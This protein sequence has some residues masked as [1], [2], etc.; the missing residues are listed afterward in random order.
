VSDETPKLFFV[1]IQ[2]TA[3]GTLRQ[4]IRAN[5][6][7]GE[8]YPEGSGFDADPLDAYW[9]IPRLLSIAPERQAQIRGYVGHFPYIVTE[10]LDTDLVTMTVLR[11]P[12]ER[13]ISYLKMRSR[14]PERQGRTVE[15]IYDD[16]FDF[17]CFILNHQTKI[18]AM[19]PDDKL[20]TF[21]DVIDVD[22]DRLEIAKAHLQEIDIL[23]LQ[24]CYEEMLAEVA[25]RFGWQVGH[26]ENSHVSQGEWEI[27]DALRARIAEDNALDIEFYQ[28][29]EQLYRERHPARATT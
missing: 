26:V 6:Q 12:I 10:L 22:R 4:T 3:G 1:H 16:P 18:F 20:E 11:D 2:K 24:E 7:P 9:T 27:T 13:T 21:M 23:G 19:T 29:A 17:P 25:E 15:D 8:I 5:L 14:D 28:F